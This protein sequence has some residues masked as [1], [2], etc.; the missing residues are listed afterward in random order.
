M[1]VNTDIAT[2]PKAVK[3]AKRYP[4]IDFL[5]GLA[6]WMMV[7]LHTL[8]RWV[9]R[10]AV[11]DTIGS[12]QLFVVFILLSAVFF[13]AWCGFFLLVS[14]VG[15]MISMQK[16]LE[17]GADVKGLAMKQILGGFILLM[18]AFLSESAIGYH[19][20]LGNIDRKSVV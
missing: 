12:Q 13:G 10:G 6:I 14:A 17:R 7:F 15:N 20:A 1:S 11:V 18:F 19:G 9:D 5:R 3:G 8:M 4:T 2:Q 16:S